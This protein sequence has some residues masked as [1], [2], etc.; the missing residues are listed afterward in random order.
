[1]GSW[2]ALSGDSLCAKRPEADVILRAGKH[3]CGSRRGGTT[4]VEVIRHAWS[5][6]IRKQW[7]FLYPLALAVI[8]TMAFLAVYAASSDNLSWS[9]FLSVNFE[10]WQYVR[11]HFLAEF[12]FTSELGIAL[13]A[14]FMVCLFLAMIRPPF[15]RAVAG[16]RYPLTP[17]RWGEVGSL[18]FYYLFQYLVVWVLP[19][20]GHER[21]VVANLL[22]MFSWVVL[23]L[24]VFADYVIVY[25]ER[26][27]LAALRR[28]VRLFSQSWLTVIGILAVS[29]L[30]FFGLHSLYAL[31]YDGT[32][33]VF[34]LL[35]VSQILVES[36]VTLFT[37]LMLIFLYEELRRRSPA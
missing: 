25:E 27:F 18:L 16:P 32:S 29:Q 4:I 26:S 17:R 19:M 35:P 15:F 5:H 28:S 30:I 24:I 2:A 3:A 21:G 23:L 11:S 34:I 10:R 8:A 20:A 31:Y 22:Q 14:G 13:F 12:S 9:S 6:L 7:L 36:V 1:M 33:R 37:D